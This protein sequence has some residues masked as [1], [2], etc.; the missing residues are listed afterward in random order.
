MVWTCRSQ[1]STPVCQC[2]CSNRVISYK[3]YI[4]YWI[5]ILYT[6]QYRGKGPGYGA[7]TVTALDTDS[8]T[9]MCPWRSYSPC[10]LSSAQYSQGQLDCHLDCMTVGTSTGTVSQYGYIPVQGTPS[11]VRYGSIA[12]TG[13]ST[14]YMDLTG[15]YAG[16]STMGY[17][18][19]G[20]RISIWAHGRTGTSIC[21]VPAPVPV[22]LHCAS[23]TSV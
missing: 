1:G 4:Y 22:L 7:C 6:I 13:R 19:L 2:T 14:P 20:T 3:Q 12:G 15:I 18:G 10:S 23:N 17:Q 8:Y 21:Q 11:T 5:S 16:R 9:C